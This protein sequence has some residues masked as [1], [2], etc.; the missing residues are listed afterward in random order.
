MGDGIDFL[1]FCFYRRKAFV[2]MRE[3]A[4]LPVTKLPFIDAIVPTN[5]KGR[6]V[7]SR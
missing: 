3:Y 4:S 1:L 2:E 7:P 5:G 6:I